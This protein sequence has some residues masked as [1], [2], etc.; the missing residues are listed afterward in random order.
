MMARILM[1]FVLMCVQNVGIV[2]AQQNILLRNGRTWYYEWDD[3]QVRYDVREYVDGDT[4]INGIEWKRIFCERPVGSSPFLEKFMRE[5]G[6][7]VF[8]MPNQVEAK[9]HLL[10]DFSVGQGFSFSKG[11][12]IAEVSATRKFESCGNI[13]RALEFTLSL[14]GNILQPKGYW[15][16]GIGSDFGIYGELSFFKDYGNNLYFRSVYDGNECVFKADVFSRKLLD[17]QPFPFNNHS[18]SCHYDL[19][20]R[21]L[22]TQPRRGLYIKD[23]RKMVV[24]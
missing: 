7:K 15:V 14:D 8:E 13:Y 4:T 24:K 6:Y 12:S 11:Y 9:E 2:F 3:W 18:A 22:T 23:G 1:F 21:R 19:Q 10:F 5:D 17:I 16:E 20:G